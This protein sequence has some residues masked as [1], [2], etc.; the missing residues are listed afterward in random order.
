MGLSWLHTCNTLYFLL[1]VFFLV[2]L[3][4]E[5]RTSFFHMSYALGLFLLF[6]LQV[7]CAFF[8]LGAGPGPRSSYLC[9]LYS[10]DY[11][12]MP[13]LLAEM[14]S[15]WHLP[16]PRLALNLDPSNFLFLSSQNYGVIHLAQS[17]SPVLFCFV[18]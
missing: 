6:I 4:F 15:C 14:G 16:R 18:F 10:W 11:N 5:L 3:E 13:S 12:T 2:E 7:V 9:L 8:F 17:A 1:F